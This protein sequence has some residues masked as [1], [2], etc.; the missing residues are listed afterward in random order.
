M[1]FAHYTEEV[2]GAVCIQSSQNDPNS[3]IVYSRFYC[4]KICY[5][6]PFFSFLKLLNN[7]PPGCH[8]MGNNVCVVAELPRDKGMWFPAYFIGFFYRNIQSF[9][10]LRGVK[11]ITIWSF[12]PILNC[13]SSRFTN[14]SFICTS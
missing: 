1:L 13:S 8:N 9:T 7:L 6:F 11:N 14:C 2:Q 3:L 5:G 10:I 4:P 12:R